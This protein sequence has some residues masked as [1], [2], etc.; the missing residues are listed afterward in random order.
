MS[1]PAEPSEPAPPA[2]WVRDHL[3]NERTLMAWLRTAL[4]FMAFGV[5]VAKFGLLLHVFGFDHPELQGELP[6]PERSQ[7]LGALL[8]AFGGGL[9]IAGAVKTRRWARRISPGRDVPSERTLFGVAIATVILAG[10]L[11]VYL[12]L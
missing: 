4:T 12:F 6:P 10:V 8:V 1:A 5:A 2:G 3:A 9:A 11:T 7:V